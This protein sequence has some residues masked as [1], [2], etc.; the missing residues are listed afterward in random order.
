MNKGGAVAREQTKKARDPY[1]NEY[2]PSQI[3]YITERAQ[4]RLNGDESCG[5]WYQTCQYSTSP[6]AE[7]CVRTTVPQ[8]SLEDGE[9]HPDRFEPDI[10]AERCEKV[11][12]KEIARLVKENKPKPKFKKGDKVA[13]AVHGAGVVSYEPHVVKAVKR[14]VVYLEGN[15]SSVFDATTGRRAKCGPDP[16]GF[17]SE[18]VPKEKVPASAWKRRCKDFG[19]ES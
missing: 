6:T 12:P 10:V 16:F 2:G 7:F 1:E 3:I 13:I 8:S 19:I 11:S 14:N 5:K 4:K 18:I 15:D 17:W 9:F